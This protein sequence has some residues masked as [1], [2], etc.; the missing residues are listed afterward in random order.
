MPAAVGAE[1]TAAGWGSLSILI[2]MVLAGAVEG[3]VLGTAQADC[4]YGWGVLPVRRRWIVAHECR[5]GCRMVAWDA[6][7]HAGRTELDGRNRRSGWNRRPDLAQ[8]FT[9]GSVLRAS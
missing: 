5:R 6:T 3:A 7:E 4:L 9:T 1:V 2:V 8:L